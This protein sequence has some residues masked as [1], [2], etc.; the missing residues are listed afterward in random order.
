MK[1]LAE[2]F[3][4][5]F[6]VAAFVPSLAFVAMAMVIFDPIIPPDLVDAM[7]DTFEPFGQSG[8]LLLALTMILGFV[9]SSLN[10]FIYKLL[11]GYF[12][13]E[14]FR[15]TRKSQLRKL[16]KY[17][18]ELAEVESEIREEERKRDEGTGDFD[19]DNLNSL[20][21]RQYYI[22]SEM[23]ARFPD[24]EDA[25]LPTR[26]GNI[27][28]AAEGYANR[29]YGIDAVHMWPRL[30]HVIPEGYYEKVEQSN[31]SLAFL[32][33]CSVLSFLFAIISVL[34]SGYQYLLWHLVGQGETELLYFISITQP[35]HFYRDRIIAYLVVALGSL[36]L[37]RLFHA[38]AFPVV[39]EYGDMI[40]SCFD[41]F[42]FDLLKQ[43]SLPLP[44]DSEQE[45]VCWQ[46]LSEFMVMG[47][48]R[49]TLKLSYEI[50][51]E[52]VKE[53]DPS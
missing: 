53:K 24:T 1:D 36:I 14:R 4:S 6:L 3:G 47:T 38:G 17:K 35:P 8:V 2:K 44:T 40:R 42:R 33:N 25:V 27:L 37:S 7:K 16:T 12:F 23:G 20:Q 26:F 45:Y 51:L 29:R 21:D 31:N 50:A 34:A 22:L 11:E 10:T 39:R 43:M 46:C 15:F 49:G 48:H 5:N 32:V 28:R 30:I 19:L 18:L 41:L 52:K 13:L 9:L